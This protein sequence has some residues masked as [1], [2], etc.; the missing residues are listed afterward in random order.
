MKN[1]NGSKFD[2]DKSSKVLNDLKQASEADYSTSTA[3]LP[4]PGGR[5][6]AITSNLRALGRMMQPGRPH[7]PVYL[8][9]FVTNSCHARCAHCFYWRE[10]NKPVQTLSLPEIDSLCASLGPMV[11]VTLTGGSPELRDD[12]PQIVNIVRR[13]CHPLNLTI[14]YT[15]DLPEVIEAQ[16]RESLEANPGL[17]LAVN[18]S[19]DGLGSDHD[20]YRRRKGL[21]DRAVESVKRLTQVRDDYPNLCVGCGICVHGL[22]SDGAIA[23]ARWAMENLSLDNLSPV[24]VR[25]D[26]YDQDARNGDVEAFL[27]IAN[28][29]RDRL[30]SG[31]FRGYSTAT[32]RLIN[33]KDIVQKEMI[34]EIARGG[35]MPVVCSALHDTAVVYADGSVPI[36]EMR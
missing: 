26:T 7:R 17:K 30:H 34:A 9:L 27:E 20:R 3:E 16:V 10:T 14:C 2:Q 19:L 5:I 18:I 31:E 12:L 1:T 25:G 8:L 21:F 28:F 4:P 6:S 15:G 32:H 36:C 35:S 13:R 11:Q 24:L 29:T 22:N 33:A 23:T